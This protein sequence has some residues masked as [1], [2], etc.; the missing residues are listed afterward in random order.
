MNLN[1]MISLACFVLV[2]LCFCACGNDNNDVTE[3]PQEPQDKNVTTQLVFKAPASFLDKN[4]TLTLDSLVLTDAATKQKTDLTEKAAAKVKNS[5]KGQMTVDVTMPEGV[6]DMTMKGVLSYSDGGKDYSLIIRATGEALTMTKAV[7]GVPLNFDVQVEK[8]ESDG[9]GLV[10]AEIFYFETASRYA[11]DAYFRIYNNSDEP[12]A[13]AGLTIAES[14][15][16]TT[17]KTVYTP[18]VINEAFT[19]WSIFRIPLDD[20]RTLAPGESILI[21]DQAVDHRTQNSKSFDLTKADYQWTPAA[22]G[23]STDVATLEKVYFEKPQTWRPS[24]KGVRSYVLAR[25]G[26]GKQLTAA[27]Y[28]GDKADANNPYYYK[29]TYDDLG[30]TEEGY[31]YKI[32]NEWIMDAVNVSNENKFKMIATSEELDKGYTGGLKNNDPGRFGTCVRRKVLSDKKLQD[33]NN[34]S[35]DFLRGQTADP[36]FDFNK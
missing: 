14:K 34:S 28:L 17:L 36:Y 10:I 35:E 20:K 8:T 15:F 33:T 13:L 30:L 4:P 2:S 19:A 21:C 23:G 22:D 24:S 16:D 6:Y 11:G 7:A 18:N 32:P 3:E 27:E 26:L 1:K 9:K 31:G 5:E 12:V 25:L 29:F